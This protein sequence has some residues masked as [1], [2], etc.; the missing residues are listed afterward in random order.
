MFW[1]TSA[2]RGLLWGPCGHGA[3]PGRQQ[4]LVGSR[5]QGRT[6]PYPRGSEGWVGSALAIGDARPWVVLR[7]HSSRQENSPP[8][9]LPFPSEWVTGCLVCTSSMF[10][11]FLLMQSP[12][13]LFSR[14]L[15]S[16]SGVKPCRFA[17]GF[18]GARIFPELC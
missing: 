17:T 12:G 14:E 10:V 1:G 6:S 5:P 15:S 16:S 4:W 8:A 7:V 2:R 13:L 18:V 11:T 3:R 9:Q